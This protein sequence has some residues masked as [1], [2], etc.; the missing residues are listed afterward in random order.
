MKNN[1]DINKLVH[2]ISCDIPDDFE[3]EP[4]DV[5]FEVWATGRKNGKDV[6]DT[7]MLL[8]TFDNP[9]EAEA[10]ANSLT[11]ADI[12]H[13][14]PEEINFY[15]DVDLDMIQIEVET[16]IDLDETSTNVGTVVRRY[17]PVDEQEDEPIKQDTI[18]ELHDGEYSLLPDSTLKVVGNKMKD[19]TIGDY[20]GII[21]ADEYHSSMPITYKVINSDVIWNVLY[22]Y[23]EFIL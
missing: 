13:E 9:E 7:E 4:G 20:V 12:V 10:Y 11:L 17:I 5:R 3:V 6:F 14:A 18:V 15:V 1:T 22:T 19:F 8:K 23:C 2:A 16:V 21:F